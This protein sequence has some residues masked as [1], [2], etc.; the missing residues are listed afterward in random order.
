M[1]NKST[2][3]CIV[4][5]V[6]L[7]EHKCN[8]IWLVNMPVISTGHIYDF[9][10]EPPLPGV[11]VMPSDTHWDIFDSARVLPLPS[12]GVTCMPSD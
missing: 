1:G 5:P 7:P 4:S 8:R 12:M 10:R 3:T 11:G 2:C 9:A 6:C